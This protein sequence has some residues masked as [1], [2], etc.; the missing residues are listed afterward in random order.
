M[1]RDCMKKKINLIF[2][3]LSEIYWKYIQAYKKK[4]KNLEK[5]Y[6]TKYQK[7][8][9]TYKVIWQNQQ[10]GEFTGPGKP[11]PFEKLEHESE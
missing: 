3:C 11:T 5:I 2:K 4:H 1:K 6:T 9:S 10:V 7:E 8:G